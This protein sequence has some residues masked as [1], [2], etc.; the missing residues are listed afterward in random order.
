MVQEQD[1]PAQ[2]VQTQ[3]QAQGTGQVQIQIDAPAETAVS[4]IKNK[5]DKSLGISAVMED[6]V[7]CLM[8]LSGDIAKFQI[9]GSLSLHFAHKLTEARILILKLFNLPNTKT[10]N[11]KRVK[12]SVD[13][14]IIKSNVSKMMN[15][16]MLLNINGNVM[17]QVKFVH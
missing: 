8:S 4:E 16:L 3:V 10:F 13:E 12:H 17:I 9:V 5:A 11:P 6:R 14:G 15:Q 2:D 7:N 1:P